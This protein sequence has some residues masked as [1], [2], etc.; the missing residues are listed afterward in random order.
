MEWLERDWGTLPFRLFLL[1]PCLPCLKLAV[2]V[3]V[4]VRS[5]VWGFLPAAPWLRPIGSTETISV[6]NLGS[7]PTCRR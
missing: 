7:T 6:R 5:G 2:S 3:V 1:V 4:P